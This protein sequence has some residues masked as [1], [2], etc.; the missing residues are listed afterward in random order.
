[1]GNLKDLLWLQN[2]AKELNIT[3]LND[4]YVNT[5]YKY[6][7]KCDKCNHIWK[8]AGNAIAYGRIDKYAGTGTRRKGCPY[9]SG[10]RNDLNSLI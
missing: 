10:K 6:D 4:I 3:V 5:A 7:L 2:K 8:A 9:C 1:M